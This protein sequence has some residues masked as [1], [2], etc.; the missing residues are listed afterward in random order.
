MLKETMK[1]IMFRDKG[2]IQQ[3]LSLKTKIDF[4]L[5]QSAKYIRTILLHVTLHMKSPVTK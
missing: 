1:E 3:L 5:Y 4:F 2:I